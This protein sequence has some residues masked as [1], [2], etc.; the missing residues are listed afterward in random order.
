[1]LKLVFSGLFLFFALVFLLIGMLKG[2]KYKFQYPLSK[3]ITVIIAAVLAVLASRLLAKLLVSSVAEI[4]LT[5]FSDSQ[6]LLQLLEKVPS[7]MAAVHALAAM[8]VAPI[9]FFLIFLIL[10]PIVGIF[11]RP[12][13]KLL[14]K[15]GKNESAEQPVA[16]VQEEKTEEMKSEATDAEAADA[17]AEKKAEEPKKAKK[18]NSK[19]AAFLSAKKFDPLGALCGA[20]CSFAVFVILLAPMVGTLTVANNAVKLLSSQTNEDIQTVCEI[21]DAAAE[22]VG[23]KT[24]RALGGKLLYNR[25]TTYSVNGEPVSL[26]RELGFV[27]SVGQAVIDI[28]DENVSSKDAAASLRKVPTAFEDSALIPTLLSELLSAASDDWSQGRS[29]C[30]I[31]CPSVGET[32]DPVVQDLM[33]VMS[34]SNRENISGDVRTIVNTLALFVENDALDAMKSDN[35]AMS[36]LKNEPLISGVMLEILENE[37]LSP[38]VNSITNVGISLLAEQLGL[39]KDAQTMYDGFVGDMSSE[40]QNI[41]AQNLSTAETVELLSKSVDDI[42]DEYGIVI[43][44]GVSKC[45][46]VDM[47]KGLSTGDAKEVEKFFASVSDET[48]S[49]SIGTSYGV[50]YLSTTDKNEGARAMATI[51]KIVKSVNADTTVEQLKDII[52]AELTRGIDGLPEG[53]FSE[54]AEKMAASMYQNIKEEKL[55]Y[56]AATFNGADEFAQNSVRITRDDLKMD[57]TAVSDKAKEADSVAKMFEAVFTV[58]DNL[59][60]EA[61]IGSIV[62][63]FGPVLDAASDCEMVGSGGAANILTAVLQSNTVRDNVGF[64]VTQATNIASS[65]NENSAKEGESYTTLMKSLG[66]TVTIIEK[67]TKEDEDATESINDLIKDMTPASAEVLKTLSTPET[68]KNYGV[69]EKNAAPVSEMLADLFGNMAVAKEEGM[70]DEQYDKEAAAIKDLL[71]LAMSVGKSGD[72]NIFGEDS[73]TGISAD[74]YIDRAKESTII[75]KTVINAAYVNGGDTAKTDPLNTGDMLSE[76]EKADFISALDSR[77]KTQ[78]SESNDAAAN[79]EFQKLLSSIAII[80]NVD[81]TISGDSVTAK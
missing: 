65:I 25:L 75:K 80:V 26:N 45:I 39:A 31:E 13:G 76:S 10:K 8:I 42:F 60:G 23:A 57:I 19:K 44:D 54:L 18:K 58:V 64:T 30:G 50:T 78:L 81:I 4:V 41:I 3:L 68:M 7:A 33:L 38:L 32:F 48:D 56:K 1:M 55:S 53:I 43:S 67:T 71:N 66:N 37:R 11:K 17:P 14:L 36:I 70:S 27:A 59:G 63:S 73:A 22:N 6:D 29:F 79:A 16:E 34:D 77:W 24:V 15:L 46:A 12:I 35:G 61:S 9:L 51:E 28:S 69:P 62:E 49:M 52:E 74:E 2:K 21:S 47:I 40:Y 72:K 20:L 5:A